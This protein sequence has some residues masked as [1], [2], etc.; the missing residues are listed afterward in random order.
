MLP[1]PRRALTPHARVRVVARSVRIAAARAAGPPP[2][3]DAAR[4]ALGLRKLGVVGSVLYVA[5]HPDDENTALLAYLANG[6]LVRTGYLSITRGDGGQNLIGSEQGAGP[7]RHPHP[8]AAGRPP[9]RRGRAV[10]HPRA[11]LRLLEEPG[12]DAA[13]LGQGRG[14]GRRGGGH[15]PL[16]PRRDRHPLLA[17]AGRHPRPPHRLGDAGAWRRSAPPPIRSF[18]PEQLTDGVTPWQ[19][20]R[21]LWN[22][23]SWSVK[24][25]DELRGV[26]QA[27]RRRL[28]PAAG[29]V[30]RRDRRRQPQHAQEPG[31]RRGAR[32]R[33]PIVEYFKLLAAADG[34]AARPTGSTSSSTGI[35]S[36]WKRFPG[37][38][39]ARRLARARGHAQFDLDGARGVAAR[40]W[41]RSTPRST[42]VPDAALAGG[43]AARAARDLMLAC[44]GLFAEATAADFRSPPG[45]RRR[46]H[47]HRAQ[48]LAGAV[49][50][51]ELALSVRGRRRARRPARSLPVAK[52][53]RPPTRDGRSA[54]CACPRTRRRATPYWLARRPQPRRLSRRPTPRS[55]ARPRARRR[56]GR[57][58]RS[59]SRGG[60]SPGARR[61]R[62][63]WTD[64]VAGER[65]RPLEVAPAVSVQPDTARA[66]VP[67]RRARSALDRAAHAR[68]AERGGHAARSRRR[69][70]G[71]SSRRRRRFALAAEG[72]RGELALQVRPPPRHARRPA[73]GA[74][75]LRRR[76]RGRRAR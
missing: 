70:A 5:A 48:P 57:R 56:C 45:A 26:H 62:Y 18:H 36:S 32:A 58:S 1:R 63:K 15:P 25:G 30:V 74:A 16:P 61:S 66:A 55:S 34:R 31:L 59:R 39:G 69:P 6:A 8:G 64:P 12:G 27:G 23:S 13:D 54:R 72:E 76:G 21:L 35:D 46:G 49:T 68:R 28:R 9:R 14:A 71:R 53:Q 29:R 67:G 11:R 47:G 75:A 22:R 41:P 73:H 42:R 24:P 43:E 50:L 40:R 33:G 3:P 38:G 2:Q 52:A 7:G 20:R 60:A 4:I 44:A 65:Y 19:A 10:L 37:G 51:A 17:R